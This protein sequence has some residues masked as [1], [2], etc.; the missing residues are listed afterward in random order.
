[1]QS[2]PATLSFAAAAAAQPAPQPGAAGGVAGPN[3]AN[4]PKKAISSLSASGA[5][6]PPAAADKPKPKPI[7]SLSAFGAASTSSSAPTAAAAAA[8]AS[9]KT[10]GE[11]ISKP[12][13][14][15]EVPAVTAPKEPVTS[16]PAAAGKD[17][18]KDKDKFPTG[19]AEKARPASQQQTTPS[20]A[21][22]VQRKAVDEPTLT[23][24]VDFV[25][26]AS[27]LLNTSGCQ[28]SVHVLRW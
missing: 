14:P 5:S 9:G 2:K 23:H 25:Q 4:R 7:A 1:V 13:K 11:Q 21:A 18:V 20:P 26:Q 17:N 28:L 6:A 8:P 10:D 15:T 27:K 12:S 24:D 16:A 22:P 19:T 3:D